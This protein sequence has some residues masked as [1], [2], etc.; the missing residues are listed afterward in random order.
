MPRLAAGLAQAMQAGNSKFDM[1]QMHLVVKQAF[2]GVLNA[3]PYVA[4]PEGEKSALE[5]EREGLI[6][7]AKERRDR[8]TKGFEPKVD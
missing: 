4:G 7:R 1:D 3:L 6:K 5:K 2:D 8:L